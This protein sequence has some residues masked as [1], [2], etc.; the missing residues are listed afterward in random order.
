MNIDYGKIVTNALS[1]LVAAVFVGAAAIVWNAANSVDDRIQNANEGIL[2]QQAA[3][4]ATQDTIVPELTRL[5]SKL[6]DIEA[7]L[8][9]LNKILAESG[10]FQGKVSYTPD[11][12]FVLD[13]F[14]KTEDQKSLEEEELSRLRN[15]ID[16]RQTQIYERSLKKE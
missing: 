2:N 4:Q 11:Q 5:R 7:Q 3:I 16:V 15:E 1:T 10:N 12:P 13:E 8:K 6:D 9:S 14:R